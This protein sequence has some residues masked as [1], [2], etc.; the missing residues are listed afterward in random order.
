MCGR[1]T[2]GSVWGCGKGKIGNGPICASSSLSRWH[3]LPSESH[4]MQDVL[5]TIGGT[6]DVPL[7]MP[8]ANTFSKSRY[9]NCSDTLFFGLF[10]VG[11]LLAAALPFSRIAAP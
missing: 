2:P 1:L 5:T 6:Q 8:T 9:A 3:T 7:Q 4:E 11:A 10:R